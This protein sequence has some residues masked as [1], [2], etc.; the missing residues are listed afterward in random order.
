MIRHSR[1]LTISLLA[2]APAV[3]LMVAVAPAATAAGPSASA[4]ATAIARNF[5]RHL[6]VGQ[7]GADHAV[8]GN[9]VAISALTQ[10]ESSNWSGYADTGSGYATVTGKWTEPGASCTS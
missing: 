8:R 4:H 6:Q 9:R 10:V 7:H 1:L 2:C 3:G 5:L